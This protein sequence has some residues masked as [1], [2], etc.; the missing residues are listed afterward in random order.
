MG[1]LR[2]FL[3]QMIHWVLGF[4]VAVCARRREPHVIS[5]Y[6]REFDPN[7]QIYLEG[8]CV[9]AILCALLES[10][11]ENGVFADQCSCSRSFGDILSKIGSFLAF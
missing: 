3:Y 11:G 5:L 7:S 2:L 9:I 10:I 8:Y 6:T 1:P 4:L